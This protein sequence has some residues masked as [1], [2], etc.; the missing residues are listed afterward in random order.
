[1]TDNVDPAAIIATGTRCVHAEDGRIVEYSVTGSTRADARTVVA[2][3][4]AVTDEPASW[5]EAYGSLNVRMINVSLPG[6]G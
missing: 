3:Y 5:T 2:G 6:S 1:M 4:F